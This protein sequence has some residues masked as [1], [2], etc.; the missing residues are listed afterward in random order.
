[1]QSWPYFRAKPR[2][3]SSFRDGDQSLM[4]RIRPVV[5]VLYT[6]SGAIGE[7]AGIA[8]PPAKAIFI[9]IGVLLAAAKDVSASHDALVELFQRIESFFRRLGVYTQISLTAEMADVF[10]KIVAEVLFILSIATKEVKRKRAKIYF[11]SLLGRTDVEG[12]W[13]RLDSLIQEEVRMAI[14]QIMKVAGNQMEL[15]VRKWFSPPDPSTNHNTACDV[16]HNVPPIWFFE[17][18][19][20][21]DWMSRGSLLWIHGKPGSGKSI[22]CSAIVQH[23]MALRDA[24]KATLAYFY[25]DFRD[26]EKQNSTDFIWHTGR[27][28]NSQAPGS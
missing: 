14:A 21:M 27:E 4:G 8:F 16:Y 28:R 6:F 3:F 26:D 24:G 2:R 13:R 23:I 25:F 1:M 12:A 19:V 17:A 20:F 22:L 7:V 10:V 5:D 15:D 18:S 9:G 11:R